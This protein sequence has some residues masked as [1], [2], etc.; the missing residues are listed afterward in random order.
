MKKIKN[1]FRYLF[2]LLSPYWKYGKLYVI[3]ML[4]VSIIV[5]PLETYLT[6][7]MPQKTI[8][9]M[10]GG[11]TRK[12]ILWVILSFTCVLIV[13]SLLKKLS[14]VYSRLSVQ[15]VNFRIRHDINIKAL[16]SDF[17]YYDTPDFYTRFLFAQDQFDREAYMAAITA[18]KLLT[19]IAT[20][21]TLSAYIA[22]VG[23]WLL[24]ITAAFVLVYT[25]LGLPKL[26]P[27]TQFHADIT[28]IRKPVNYLERLLKQKENAA[29]L[30]ASGAG[31][32]FVDTFYGVLLRFRKVGL[33]F[34]RRVLP[35]DIAES[36]LSPLQGAVVL[37]FILLFVIDGDASKIGL[38]AS[39][40]LASTAIINSLKTLFETLRQLYG[41]T[42]YAERILEFFDAESVIEPLQD[43]GDP[44]PD[45]PFTVE[46]RDLSFHYQNAAP[47][48]DHFNLKIEPGRRVAIVGE[49]GAGKSTLLKLL[50]RLYDPN[51][52][53][54]LIN[55]KDI[56]DY[57]V[58][59]LRMKI[60]V[61]FQDVC[62]LA[63]RLRDTMTVY[64]EA[65]DEEITRAMEKL[66]LQHVLEKA[67]YDFDRVLSREFTEDG[68]ALSGGEAQRLA[69]ARLLLGEF[70]LLIL[71]EPSSAL[72]PLAE[73][74]LMDTITEMTQDTT[75]IMIAHRLSTVRDFDIIYYIEDGKI[76]EAGSHDE[77]MA[78]RGK[79][80]TMFTT[81]AK[82]Y[83]DS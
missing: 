81:Q 15:K 74:R 76:A 6:A 2:F 55:N 10:M 29:E 52:G 21:C 48:F 23:P 68:I 17:K 78:Q 66:G 36:L 5:S 40:T 22:A 38:Y 63:M 58:H 61:A 33:R 79:Y 42:M 3:S 71:D 80:Y 45:G 41:M 54:V 60:G 25:L 49:N 30:R 46:L 13:L 53:A 82:K 27:E 18:P 70:G 35:F 72:D 28:E 56:R 31:L 11:G 20:A 50:I 1:R 43:S 62:I 77:L 12:E 19:S 9:R 14:E 51:G 67:D 75:T 7:L 44:P 69:L 83:H 39:L 4:L 37:G 65:S 34:I 26:K 32:K 24:G 47:L 16:Y 64:H 59:A 57:D 8:D 73:A